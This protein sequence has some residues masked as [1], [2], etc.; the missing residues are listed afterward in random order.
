MD[1]ITLEMI[2]KKSCY[3]LIYNLVLFRQGLIAKPGKMLTELQSIA[4]PQASIKIATISMP[5]SKLFKNVDISWNLI[6]KFNTRRYQFISHF[7][8]F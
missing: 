8:S 6:K 3:V 5:S 2:L 7:A 1:R 4:I